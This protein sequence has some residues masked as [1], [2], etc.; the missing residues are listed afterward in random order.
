MHDDDDEVESTSDS[1]EMEAG[2]QMDTGAA[3]LLIAGTEVLE[4]GVN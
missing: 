2:L 4:G 3:V 1:G